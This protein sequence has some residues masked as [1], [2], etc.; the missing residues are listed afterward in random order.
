MTAISL[1][2]TPPFGAYGFRLVG[3]GTEPV[4]PDLVPLS[5][6]HETVALTWRRASSLTTKAE[7][8]TEEL[9]LAEERGSALRMRRM[10]AEVVLDIPEAMSARAFVH[11]TLAVPL[12]L[13][14]RWRGYITLH[15][16]AFEENGA[17]GVL[18]DRTAGKSSMLA[19]LADRGVP[20][21]SD[22]LLVVHEGQ[23]L[24]GPRCVDLRPDVVDRFPAADSL[25][26]VAGRERFRLST[27][28]APSRTVLR[29]FFV[30]EWSDSGELELEP[31]GI[32]QRLKLLYGQEYMGI[33][34]AADP[35]RIVELVGL[36]AWRLRRP[37]DW[38]VTSVVVDRLLELTGDQVWP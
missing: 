10:P 38:A 19:A 8:G 16:G 3:T 23:A 4:L 25:G 22:D 1:T 29:G 14:A 12:S 36:P 20:I 31:I 6:E 37:R 30:L 11:P 32:H 2:P 24:A 13:L 15:A 34:G 35:R 26:V 27:P 21:V 18:G 28:L 33:V 17:W 9:V 5:E 7:L